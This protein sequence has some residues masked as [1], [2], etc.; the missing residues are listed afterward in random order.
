MHHVISENH[1][2]E[3]VK[4]CTDH[5]KDGPPL[6]MRVLVCVH[7]S[8]TSFSS[9][10]LRRTMEGRRR[11]GGRGEAGEEGEE[12]GELVVTEKGQRSDNQ[13]CPFIGYIIK[14][15]GAHQC[16]QSGVWLR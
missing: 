2:F 16:S 3:A 1:S 12:R 7:T 5:L 14:P 6:R 15:Q 10:H 13:K 4:S 11:E 8:M 9:R